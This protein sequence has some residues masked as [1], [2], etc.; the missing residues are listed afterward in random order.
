[1]NDG[2]SVLTEWM[3]AAISK[4]W[5]RNFFMIMSQHFYR[6]VHVVKTRTFPALAGTTIL[7]ITKSN[8]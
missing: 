7:A 6:N 8:G 3:M 2:K 5:R 4:R 1:M